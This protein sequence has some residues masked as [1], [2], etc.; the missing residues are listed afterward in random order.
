MW[1]K[2]WEIRNGHHHGVEQEEKV[3]RNREK[4]VYQLRDLYDK[5]SKTLA[6]D[7]DIYRTS[8]TEH[9]KESTFKRKSWIAVNKPLIR[10]SMQ[11]KREKEK[12]HD[13]RKYFRK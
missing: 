3:R 5:K 10:L 8:L 6:M 9:L 1:L 11:E 12:S 2:L 13:I 7:Q 4:L